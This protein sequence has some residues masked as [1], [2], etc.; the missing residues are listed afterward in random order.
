MYC[1]ITALKK[2]TTTTVF[3][4][5]CNYPQSAQILQLNASRRGKTGRVKLASEANNNNKRTGEAETTN[6]I[7][8]LHI[9]PFCTVIM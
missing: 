8:H 3:S 7:K 1:V 4:L 6:N 9:V 2:T 5:R